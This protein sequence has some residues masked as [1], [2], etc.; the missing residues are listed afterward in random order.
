MHRFS[1]VSACTTILLL[2]ATV[3]GQQT[4][5]PDLK[6]LTDAH[7]NI[8][9]VQVSGEDLPLRMDLRLP[10]KGWTRNGRLNPGK[11]AA[12]SAKGDVK[13][14]QGT[15]ELGKGKLCQYEMSLSPKGASVEIDLKVVAEADLDVEG[16]YLW[17][18]L[19]VNQ[20]LGGQAFLTT[21]NGKETSAACPR[22]LPQQYIFLGG[23]A[24]RARIA[25]AASRTAVEFQFDRT[26]NAMLQDDRKFSGSDYSFMFQLS[27]GSLKAGQETAVRLT[28]TPVATPDKAAA[29][30]AIDATQ[31]RYT[32]DGFGGNYCFAIDSPPAQ[33]TLENLRSAWARIEMTT[34]AWA[35]D[36]ADF[37]GAEP[38]WKKLESRDK[39]G[40][41]LRRRF[42]FDRQLHDRSL[43]LVASIWWLPEWL[44]GDGGR[45]SAEGQRRIVPRDKWPK[46][47]EV[48]GSYLLHEK[49]RYGVEPKLFSFNESNIGVM[50]LMTPEEHRDIIKF[51]GAHFAR[52]GLKTKMLLG[53]STGA[54]SIRF[55]AAAVADPEALSYVGAVAF[56]S[57]GGA[58]ADVYAGWAELADRLKLPL[59]VTELGV[60]A[61]YAGRPHQQP[62]YGLREVR[63]YQELLLHARPAGTM[64]WEF[65]SD[66][67]LVDWKKKPDGRIEVL[68]TDRYFFAQHFCN[69]TPPHSDA[70]ASRSDHAKV[71][72][73]A[74]AA[75]SGPQRVYTIHI[76]N[77]GLGRDAQLTGLPA[78]VREFRAICT[79]ESDSFRELARVRNTAGATALTLPSRS[80]LTLTN[81][82]KR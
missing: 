13:S 10:A 4:A 18:Q 11:P 65:T 53:D 32:L 81:L 72:V 77:L 42:E 21:E 78:G 31:V 55:T 44:Y 80:L 58:E 71:L 68:P 60:D 59:L 19:P 49:R 64:Y 74:F 17:A 26:I 82:P 67:S 63:M 79:S 73:T 70:L 30:L 6:V 62:G 69:L 15:I 27:R 16:V 35:P 75:G 3:R 9:G 54:G 52:L 36:A 39:P 24:K 8:C 45:K 20:F 2:A 66:Y 1:V 40:S 47:A 22:I 50:V 56:H 41:P 25:D 43:P 23:P 34:A 38:D 76:A 51:L 37:G 12:A 61:G 46:L 33:Y 14:W 28:L 7:G 48:I 57:W 5:P 29:K